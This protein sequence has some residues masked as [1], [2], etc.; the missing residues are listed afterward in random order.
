MPDF[1]LGPG[2]AKRRHLQVERARLLKFAVALLVIGSAGL[3]FLC[4]HGLNPPALAIPL[5]LAV[6]AV[7]FAAASAGL[8]ALAAALQLADGDEDAGDDGRGPGEG[9][10]D[11]AP[12]RGPV[13]GVQF[14]W[15]R[16]EREFWLYCDRVP[17]GSL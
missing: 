2:A 8:F 16:F 11:P 13:G 17:A 14:D 3:V 9:F 4:V 12:P 6:V 7:L 1:E 15:E 10:D 5:F